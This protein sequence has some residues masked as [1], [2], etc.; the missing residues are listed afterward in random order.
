VRKRL[1]RK[2]NKEK[3]KNWGRTNEREK[4]NEDEKK[5]GRTGQQRETST[6]FLLG[7]GKHSYIY[8]RD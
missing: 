6:H 7:F 8:S 3:E 4:K 5:E 1:K 2:S